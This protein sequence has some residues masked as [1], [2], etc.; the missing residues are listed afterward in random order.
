MR[1]ISQKRIR[2]IVDGFF[3]RCGKG[4]QFGIFDLSKISAAGIAAYLAPAATDAERVVACGI[5][6]QSAVE[7]YAL[8]AGADEAMTLSMDSV[9]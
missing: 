2:E 9:Q 6:V 5:A 4:K 7:K 1:K 3:Y 8:P